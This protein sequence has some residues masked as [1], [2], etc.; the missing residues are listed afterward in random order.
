MGKGIA[1]ITGASAG[2]GRELARLLAKEPD[3]EELWAIAR[4]AEKLEKLRGELGEKIRPIPLDLSAKE[5]IL[6]LEPLLQEEK[7]NIRYLVNNAGFAKLCSY[8]DL[9]VEESVNMIDLNCSGVVAMGLVCLPYMAEGSRMLNVASQASFQP[10]PYQNI[11]S[12]TKAFVRNYSRALHVELRDRGITVTAVCPGWMATDLFDR[13][14][15]GAK[16]ATSR[17]VGMVAPDKVAAKALRDAK[18][19]KDISVYSFY[20]KF[21]HVAAKLL[22]QRAMMRLWLMQQRMK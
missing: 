19:G 16:K 22:P 7:P 6:G 4:G 20:V 11:Y 9:G 12:S 10:L 13:A 15:I 1:V 14:Q 8:R 3:V 18:R 5:N 21:C 2:F 17:F